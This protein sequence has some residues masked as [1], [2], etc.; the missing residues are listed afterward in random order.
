MIWKGVPRVDLQDVLALSLYE[1]FELREVPWR[2][3]EPEGNNM[4]AQCLGGFSM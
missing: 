4:R 3:C 2:V 1:E